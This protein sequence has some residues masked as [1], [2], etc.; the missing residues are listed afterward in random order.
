MRSNFDASLPAQLFAGDR[1]APASDLKSVSSYG[2]A[3][4][5]GHADQPEERRFADAADAASAGCDAV[6]S[7]EDL[8]SRFNVSTKTIS[9]WREHGLVAERHIVGGR[10]RVGFLA[11]AVDRFINSNPLRIVRGSRFSQLSPDEHDRII[12]WARRLALAGACPADVHRQIAS[13]LNR[14]V[15]TIRY[16]IKRH[17]QEHPSEAVFP[18]A[19]GR[20]RPESCERIYQHYDGGETVESIAKRYHRSKASIYRVILSQRAEHIMQLPLDCIP[21]ALF[22]RR[23]AERVVNQPFPGLDEP[24]KRVRRPTGLPAYLASLYEVPLLTREQ[25]VWLFRKFNFLKHKATTLRAQ[26]DVDH[27]NA[28]LMDQ[29]DRLYGEIVEIKNRIVRSNLR[30]VVSIAKRRVSPGDSFFDLVSDGNMSLIRAV[31]KFDYARGNKFSTYGSWAIMKNYARTIPD[32][33]KRRDRFRAADMELLQTAT[34]RR[35]DEYQKRLAE[36]DRLQQVGQFLDRLDSR[37]QT[38]IIRR[39]GLDHEHEPQTLKEVGSALGV[40]KERVRQIEAKAMEKLREAA[41][42]NA[43]LPE[44]E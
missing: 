24:A 40:T 39:Y 14:S 9:R 26:L 35:P 33:H 6:L 25:E 37:E 30:L 32:E 29:I 20:L 5:A 13:R 3:I 21:N 27:P 38:I 17:D 19:D 23:S 34:D 12:G 7:I 4:D 41:A 28:R 36:N 16:T 43:V 15:E 44:L 1:F 42:E 8:A 2:A 22:S 31:E 10:R 11:S 18:I